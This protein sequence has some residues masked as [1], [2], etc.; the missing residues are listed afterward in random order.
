MLTSTQKSA[1]AGRTPFDK[2]DKWLNQKRGVVKAVYDF[3]VQ[4]GAVGSLSLKDENGDLIILPAG[5]IITQVYVHII[6]AFVSTSNDGTIALT[7][8]STG[9][10][11]AAVDADTLPLSANH[12]SSGV[13]IGTAATMVILTAQRQIVLEIATHAMTAGKAAFFIEFVLSALT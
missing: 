7:S 6:T 3:A 5:A 4:G 1:I 12:P 8:N 11:L 10:L 2:M 9:D 13:P